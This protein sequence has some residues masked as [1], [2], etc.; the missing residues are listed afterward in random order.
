MIKENK[1][2]ADAHELVEVEPRDLID[3]IQKAHEDRR[4]KVNRGCYI[5]RKAGLLANSENIEEAITALLHVAGQRLHYA[6]MAMIQQVAE[7][8]I[9]DTRKCLG[10]I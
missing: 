10:K 9:H 7:N 3:S 4:Q 2:S 6:E 1:T 8:I 5:L